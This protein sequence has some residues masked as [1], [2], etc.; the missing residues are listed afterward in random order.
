MMR[1]QQARDD[2]SDPP[3]YLKAN[4]AGKEQIPNEFIAAT[5]Y[6]RKYAIRVLKHGPQPKGLKK[7]GRRKACQSEVVQVL[8][9]I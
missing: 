7:P 2:R 8:E 9:Q 4:K 3:R 1:M 5:G 6:H